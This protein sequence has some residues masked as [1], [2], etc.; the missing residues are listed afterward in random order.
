MTGRKS[1][2]LWSNWWE[3]YLRA[4]FINEIV[5]SWIK[6]INSI[7]L[8]AFYFDRFYQL[9]IS[10]V[11]QIF[12]AAHVCYMFVNFLKPEHFNPGDKLKFADLKPGLSESNENIEEHTTVCNRFNLPAGNYMLI[13]STFDPEV[14]KKFGFKIFADR[15]IVINILIWISLTCQLTAM[16]DLWILKIIF[17]RLWNWAKFR[18]IFLNR[19][20]VARVFIGC[21]VRV[22]IIVFQKYYRVESIKIMQ[23]RNVWFCIG[24]LVGKFLFR[25]KF[26]NKKMSSVKLGRYVPKLLINKLKFFTFSA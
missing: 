1:A 9:I 17:E 16:L 19:C 11:A 3:K 4:T 13:P 25:W 21:I 5:F 12:G 14:E 22:K 24:N 8:N 15:S 2:Q 7:K 6:Y 20:F 18:P 26:M 10:K 23:S